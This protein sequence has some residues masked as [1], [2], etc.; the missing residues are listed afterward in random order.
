MLLHH[1]DLTWFKRKGPWWAGISCQP[2]FALAT[3]PAAEC[4]PPGCC[5][6]LS[7]L[8]ILAV[9]GSFPSWTSTG[10]LIDACAFVPGNLLLCPAV[11]PEQTRPPWECVQ[12]MGP[13]GPTTEP[14]APSATATSL[15]DG[16]PTLARL[17]ASRVC[18]EHAEERMGSSSPLAVRWQK[19]LR[20]DSCCG[21]C[22]APP[23]QC[24][25]TVHEGKGSWLQPESTFFPSYV[26]HIP[27]TLT[28][29][30]PEWLWSSR[31]PSILCSCEAFRGRG[32]SELGDGA[33]FL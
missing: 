26:P 25:L 20:I 27:E 30:G 1:A 24:P 6:C 23:G 33:F 2:G 9:C 5:G 31:H 13:Q 4:F 3:V 12:P 14:P 7:A 11:S 22:P 28:T 15:S 32:P 10:E 16:R 18:C 21:G 8:N 19:L 17:H 29:T